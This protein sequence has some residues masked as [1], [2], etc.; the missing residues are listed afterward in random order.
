MEAMTVVD[1]QS[2]AA[3]VFRS[4]ESTRRWLGYAALLAGA[5]LLEAVLLGEGSIHRVTLLAALVAVVMAVVSRLVPLVEVYPQR[6]VV[7]AGPLFRSRS[8]PLTALEAVEDR[9]GALLAVVHEQ[10][11]LRRIRIPLR[12]LTDSDRSRLE[13][14]LQDAL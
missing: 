11:R 10:G 14:L 12:Y 8:I 13:Q 5:C 7:A 2:P 9:P 4:Y 3:P 1:S 6:L